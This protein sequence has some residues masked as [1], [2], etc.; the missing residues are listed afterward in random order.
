MPQILIDYFKEYR[1]ENELEQLLLLDKISGEV[2]IINDNWEK[3]IWD[4][5]HIEF[6]DL[7]GRQSKDKYWTDYDL[8]K[9][10]KDLITWEF[11]DL[12]IREVLNKETGEIKKYLRIEGNPS[13]TFFKGKN[14]GNITFKDGLEVVNKL[15]NKFLINIYDIKLAAKFEPSVT[16][17]LPLGIADIDLENNIVFRDTI[18]DVEEKKYSWGGFLGY[19][20]PQAQYVK[21]TYLTGSK[22]DDA[23]L[24]GVRVELRYSKIEPFKKRT[25]IKTWGDLFTHYG[26]RQCGEIV[27]EMWRGVIFIDPTLRASEK[28]YPT[29]INEMIRGKKADYWLGKFERLGCETT[30]KKYLK[31]YNAIA[32]YKGKGLHEKIEKLIEKEVEKFP[33]TTSSLCGSIKNN[34]IEEVSITSIDNNNKQD[35]TILP[36]KQEQVST[37]VIKSLSKKEK[38]V[39]DRILAKQLEFNFMKALNAT[40]KSIND[41]TVAI[42]KLTKYLQTKAA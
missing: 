13:T 34:I 15:C 24:N 37:P 9:V 31:E 3:E 5:N 4:T 7:I 41:N 29:Y 38:A 17:F 16:P 22:F 30:L 35:K 6:R 39:N 2:E 23:S 18:G 25:G 28:N 14:F 36:M 40:M 10:H 8:T 42:N 19:E 20:A 27:L 21:K 32:A 33:N 26:M 1:I 12:T 11:W